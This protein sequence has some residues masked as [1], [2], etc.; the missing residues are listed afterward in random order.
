MVRV[1]VV[2]D[3]KALRALRAEEPCSETHMLAKQSAAGICYVLVCALMVHELRNPVATIAAGAE[4]LME[5]DTTPAQV[6]K[7]AANVYRAAGPDEG[8][9]SGSWQ[10]DVWK[11]S[12]V[13]PAL[14][15]QRSWRIDAAQVAAHSPVF[16]AMK[17][18]CRIGTRTVNQEI[19]RAKPARSTTGFGTVAARGWRQV[20]VDGISDL[21]L[22]E[23]SNGVDSRPLC[24]QT[25]TKRLLRSMAA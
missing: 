21:W 22:A 2:M 25:D 9:V 7:R 10:C 15:A 23:R 20:P 11:R 18:Y 5:V 17:W 4:L 3:A 8:I 6:K 13:E 24:R 16:Q 12:A 14:C 19:P 1:Y